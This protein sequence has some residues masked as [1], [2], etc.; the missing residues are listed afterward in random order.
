LRH[1]LQEATWHISEGLEFDGYKRDSD[2]GNTANVEVSQAIVEFYAGNPDNSALKTL[3]QIAI[4]DPASVSPKWRS[5]ID[6]A[7]RI[8]GMG[9]HEA[10]PIGPPS[11]RDGGANQRPQRE[12]DPAAGSEYTITRA[13]NVRERDDEGPHFFLE[14]SDGSVLLMSGQHLAD[15][16]H[17][18]DPDID[19]P[20]FPNSHMII[21]DGDIICTGEPLEYDILP[22]SFWDVWGQGYMPDMTVIT[23]VTFDELKRLGKRRRKK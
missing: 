19:Q 3:N 22:A 17:S 5:V 4:C 16:G 11:K 2:K 9:S 10:D 1:C 6:A 20:R 18:E 13:F 8:L 12:P 23:D 7:R 21:R 14:L 15:I